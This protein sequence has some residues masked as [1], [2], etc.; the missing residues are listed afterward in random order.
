MSLRT[1]KRRLLRRL[2]IIPPKYK[3]YVG[4]GQ[5]YELMG[6]VQFE[7]LRHW[8]LAPDRYLL[9]IGC[10]S[11]RGGRLA[12]KFM[13]P[14][15]YY[16]IEPNQWLIDEGVEHELGQKMFEAKRPIFSNDADFNLNIFGRQF[17]FLMAQSIFSHTSQAQMRT[18]LNEAAKVMHEKSIF[19]ATY[20]P[21]EADYAGAGWSYPDG[22]QFTFARVRA[23]AAEAQLECATVKWFHPKQQWLVFYHRSNSAFVDERLRTANNN[24]GTVRPTAT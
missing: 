16:G 12:I 13:E 8:G 15:H 4:P 9:D 5:N 20:I 21:G 18:I 6:K 10:G 2:G 3:S 23:F 19:L 14:A 17:D 24:S 1:F 11:L 22:V 7:H